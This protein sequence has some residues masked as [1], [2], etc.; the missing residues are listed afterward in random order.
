MCHPAG[1]KAV[2]NGQEPEGS[3]WELSQE[4][5]EGSGS[6]FSCRLHRSTE[7]KGTEKCGFVPRQRESLKW[8][9]IQASALFASS[10]D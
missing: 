8:E 1:S 7:E 10:E 3:C 6:G 2:G 9:T 4:D 5:M